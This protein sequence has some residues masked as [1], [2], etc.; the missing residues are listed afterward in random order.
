[1]NAAER[2]VEIYY[3]QKR[4]FTISDVKVLSGNNRQIDLLVYDGKEK[5]HYHV[6][7]SVSHDMKWAPTLDDIYH[8]MHYKFFGA[9]KFG[10]EDNKNSDSGR[11][12]TYLESIKATYKDYNIDY[13]EVVR[14]YCAWCL[15][16]ENDY[17][18]L[19]KWKEEMGKLFDLKADK[20]EILSLKNDVIPSLF[21][22]PGKSN[23][24]DEL[25]RCISLF[26]ASGVY[27]RQNNL[28]L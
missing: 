22:K 3:R 20:F 17:A 14:V 5:L 24:E 27:H 23:Y 21:E 26:D 16:T 13:K 19:P 25:L 2:L 10:K 4:C 6:E 1:M 9:V 18:N 12:K 28:Q 11:G 8:R 7:V 15:K